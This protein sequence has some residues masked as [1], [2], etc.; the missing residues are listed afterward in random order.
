[1]K[2]MNDP[3]S[4]EYKYPEGDM[5]EAHEPINEANARLIAAAPTMLGAIEAAIPILL[6]A[7]AEA[8]K[9]LDNAL[10]ERCAETLDCLTAALAK[11]TKGG[12]EA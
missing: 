1:M 7:Q 10:A 11:A 6:V 4:D 8:N 2:N 12:G 3:R 9:R 5:N